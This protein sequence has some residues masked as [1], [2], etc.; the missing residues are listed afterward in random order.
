MS[1]VDLHGVPDPRVVVAAVVTRERGLQC[2]LLLPCLC[3][4]LR[5]TKS[6]NQAADSVHGKD[7]SARKGTVGNQAIVRIFWKR[8]CMRSGAPGNH[9]ATPVNLFPCA[10]VPSVDNPLPIEVTGGRS[11]S[12][13]SGSGSLYYALKKTPHRPFG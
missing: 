1:E 3:S 13:R 10:S 8:E 11:G 9:L 6:R 2:V 12:A 7:G 4:L 5:D